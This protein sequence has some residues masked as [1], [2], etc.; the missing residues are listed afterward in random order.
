MV[1]KNQNTFAVAFMCFVR[2]DN[3]FKKT[4]F[5]LNWTMAGKKLRANKCLQF[6][7]CP[8]DVLVINT[9]T[10]SV[11]AHA[12]DRFNWAFKMVLVFIR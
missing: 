12:E 8:R 2:L 3:S 11:C 9:T 4:E 1:L 7:T 5:Q 10:I 6:S